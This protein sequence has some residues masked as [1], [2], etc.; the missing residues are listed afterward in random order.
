MSSGLKEA[1]SVT[2][3]CCMGWLSLQSH[4]APNNAASIN[5]ASNRSTYSR[6]MPVMI[7]LLKRIPNE[8][9]RAYEDG[10]FVTNWLAVC[11]RHSGF[12]TCCKTLRI[13]HWRKQETLSA[14]HW[15]LMHLAGGSLQDQYN[16]QVFHD[17]SPKC[18]AILQILHHR[19]STGT[20][21]Q[22]KWNKYLRT[23]TL[24]HLTCMHHHS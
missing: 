17:V 8:I 10:L 2:N 12:I 23:L 9:L 22:I 21:Q 24:I 19:E 5:F 4:V 1:Y 14:W 20:H 15:K 16:C 18:H 6:Y 7:L 11:L 3:I 13:K